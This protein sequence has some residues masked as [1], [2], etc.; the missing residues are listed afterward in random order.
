MIEITADDVVVRDLTVR[1]GSTEPYSGG[2]DL[3][4]AGGCLIERCVATTTW[5]G[6]RL[7][8]ATKNTVRACTLMDVEYGA[9]LGDGFVGNTFVDC[10][11]TNCKSAAYNAYAGSDGLRLLRCSA[12]FC[13]TGVQIG[14]SKDWVVECCDLV[15]NETGVV[16]DTATNGV[17]RHC[18]VQGGT[19][20]MWMAG[21]G[22]TGNDVYGNWFQ[23]CA[24]QGVVLQGS[25]TGNRIHDNRMW[26]GAGGGVW[27]M[28]NPSYP[29]HDNV[30]YRNDFRG[31]TI[32]AADDNGWDH[33][34]FFDGYPGG[35]YWDNATGPDD[36]GGVYQDIPGADGVF[37]VPHF[38]YYVE[39]AYPAT[40]PDTTAPRTGITSGPSG[41]VATRD[42]AFTWEGADDRTPPECLAYS[43]S[44]DG[45]PWLLDTV[46]GISFEG[47]AEGEHTLR[48]TAR[49]GMGN[50]DP[51]GDTRTFGV[52]VTAPLTE[53]DG[54]TAWHKTDTTVHF[55]A[56]DE[57][58]GVDY[59]EYSLDGGGSWTPGSEV[60]IPAPSDGS[61][62]G[63]FTVFYRSVDVA[64]NVEEARSCLVKISALGFAFDHDGAPV[65][66]AGER[67]N[68]IITADLDGDGDLDVIA[69]CS[70]GA[71]PEVVVYENDGTP[72]VGDWPVHVVGDSV[73][74]VHSIG[75]ADLDRDGY[76]DLVQGGGDAPVGQIV[77][78]ENDGT[79]F[80]GGWTTHQIGLVTSGVTCHAEIALADLDG[81]LWVDVVSSA[82]AYGGQGVA[83]VWPNDGSPW[84]SPWASIG[85]IS[86]PSMGSVA[87]AD[88]N[89]DTLPDYAVSILEGHVVIQI[90]PGG[91]LGAASWI[92]QYAASCGPGMISD[93]A[94]AD[95]DGDGD[96]DIATSIGYLPSVAQVVSVNPSSDGWPQ[97]AYADTAATSVAAGDLD[98]DGVVDLFTGSHGA[99]PEVNAHHGVAPG[100]WGGFAQYTVADLD[101][102]VRAVRLADLDGDGDLDAVTGGDLSPGDEVLLFE[103]LHTVDAVD[104]W[105]WSTYDGT[106]QTRSADLGVRR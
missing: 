13:G 56:W 29:N 79:P 73:E 33:N 88:F 46:T 101:A 81:D 11:A 18:R 52:D 64:G 59:T 98:A 55:T 50:D 99:G 100:P 34:E 67:V 85:Q 61:G 104:P 74:S 39:D 24:S 106:W 62:D 17:V 49:D 77:A 31:H 60:T 26:G 27:V 41:W 89:G 103:N 47:L 97:V 102:A 63:D 16:L 86:A 9:E 32:H 21:L 22:T 75:A 44:L 25:C 93:I 3:N 76:L 84:D 72:F 43:S 12:A 82:S 80:D 30:F 4:A 96:S 36:Y 68:D 51:S 20:G 8:A 69:G 95:F 70:L 65:G 48:V 23:D 14:W 92:N 58:S 66:G 105:S 6:V 2:I 78:W 5:A 94:P 40:T 15:G 7:Y 54:D 42:V 91:P 57:F 71:E 53:D 83:S 28:Y 35:N 90:N 87:I 37:D 38:E 10:Q 45:E 19:Y 1:N